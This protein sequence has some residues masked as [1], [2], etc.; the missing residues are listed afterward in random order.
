M[1][2]QRGHGLGMRAQREGLSRTTPR[3]ST[4]SNSKNIFIL[5]DFVQSFTGAVV[6]HEGLDFFIVRHLERGCLIEFFSFYGTKSNKS[7]ASD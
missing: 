7:K 6:D 2:G 3:G 4:Y 1:R 5:N